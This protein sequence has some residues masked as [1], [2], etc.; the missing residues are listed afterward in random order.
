MIRDAKEKDLQKIAKEHGITP[1]KSKQENVK[2]MKLS[3]Q[4]RQSQ[5]L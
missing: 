3:R 2:A 5:N 1:Q 4:R